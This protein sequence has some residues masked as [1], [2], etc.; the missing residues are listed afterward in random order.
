LP[1]H[2]KLWKYLHKKNCRVFCARF[3][4]NFF[5]VY[6]K[7]MSV[8]NFPNASSDQD[9][10]DI[11]WIGI[12][13]S[14]CIKVDTRL[15][16]VIEMRN[17]AVEHLDDPSSIVV[18]VLVIC[19]SLVTLFAG[20]RLFRFA[21]SFSA[22]GFAFYAVYTF[23]RTTG[24]RVSCEALIIVS[25]IVAAIAAIA[26]GC[27]LKAGLFS[28][29]AAAMAFIVHMIYSAFT[30]LHYIG[31]QPILAEKSLAYW[32]LMLLAGI[33]GGLVLRWN[34]NP[35]LEVITSCV[36][37]AGMAYSLHA[38]ADIAGANVDEWVFMASGLGA[39]VVGIVVQRH[40]RLH[41]C[42]SRDRS[43][44]LSTTRT[45]APRIELREDHGRA[46]ATYLI[47]R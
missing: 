5:V 39:T 41:G 14:I 7:I 9:G 31:N 42:K 8:S 3:D 2:T 44:S 32:G 47:G 26:A 4:C 37:G 17:T 13:D 36:G 33:A 11:S 19:A 24:D 6:R 12:N 35:I 23:G 15:Q 29:G 30:Q 21:A 38:I 20:A 16:Q 43:D 45:Q 1:A 10:L 22:A 25:S 27:I 46:S 34:S 40:L 28:V 18:P